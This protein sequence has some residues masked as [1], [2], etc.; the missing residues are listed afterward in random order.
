MSGILRN[1]SLAALAV[2]LATLSSHAQ[3]APRPQPAF[4]DTCTDRGRGVLPLLCNDEPGVNREAI[5]AE[6]ASAVDFF[7]RRL[8]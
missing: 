2:L 7:E 1:T 8:K 3:S 4:L 6:T 5:H